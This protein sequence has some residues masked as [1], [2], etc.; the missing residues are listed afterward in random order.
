MY[1][2]RDQPLGWFQL[3]NG[4]HVLSFVCVGKDERS[5]GYGLGINSVV[6]EKVPT[7]EKALPV[8]ERAIGAN[9]LG[10]AAREAVLRIQGKP[11]PTWW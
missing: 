3:T 1:V 6:L 9:R 11:I 8:L 4:R 2:A 5:A 7:V 10:A